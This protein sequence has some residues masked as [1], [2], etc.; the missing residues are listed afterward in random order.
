[1]G[2]GTNPLLPDTDGDS[3]LDGDEV[4]QYGTNPL[5]PDSDSDGLTDDE[6]ISLG[7]NPN[8]EDS[9]ND[10]MVDA[11]EISK[12]LNPLVNDSD[13]DNDGDGLTN[14]EEYYYWSS[15][16]LADTDN[17][18]L[19][20]LYE[21]LNGSNP[22]EA[23]TISDADND[24]LEAH[25]ETIFGTSDM[26]NDSDD[27]NL[28]DVWDKAT[29]IANEIRINERTDGNQSN[30]STVSN[31]DNYFVVWQGYGGREQSARY[32]I[33]GTVTD[34]YGNRVR[35][36][37]RISPNYT[38]T[39]SN[40]SVTTD[41]DNYFVV[42]DWTQ[43]D[44]SGAKVL[45]QLFDWRGDA[46]G[47][48][49]ELTGTG[50][51]NAS[52]AYMGDGTNRYLLVY[53][54]KDS[55]E[56]YGRFLDN[57]GNPLGTEFRIN[58]YTSS[59]QYNPAVACNGTNYLVAWQSNGQDGS[60]YGIYGQTINSAGEKVGSEIKISTYTSYE[61]STPSV[62]SDGINYYVTWHS[63]YQD[64]SEYGI[65][66]Q[67]LDGNGTRRGGE[68]KIN[69]T[70]YHHQ[71]SP[72]ATSN[73]TNYMVSWIHYYQL[74]GTWQ[75]DVRGKL[76]D[77]QGRVLGGEFTINKNITGNQYAPSVASD[78]N[79]YYC[80]W[81]SDSQDGS[82]WG[83]YG[84][85]VKWGYGTN[86]LLPDTD[87]DGMLDGDEILIGRDP[88][89][90]DIQLIY[91]EGGEYI[92]GGTTIGIEW[93]SSELTGAEVTIEFSNDGGINWIILAVIPRTATP[94]L[95]TVPTDKDSSIAKISITGSEGNIKDI[96]GEFTIDSVPP[97]L[98]T[99]NPLFTPTHYSYQNIS[100]TKEAGSSLWLN[101][102]EIISLNQNV[103]WSYKMILSEG[104]NP[105]VLFSRDAAGNQSANVSDVIVYNDAPP[106][107][108]NTLNLDGVD[109]G[110]VI[111]YNWTGY[112][113]Q[114]QGDI[115]YYRIYCEI[116]DAGFNNLSSLIPVATVPAGTFIYTLSGRIEDTGYFC[117]VV[118]V[119]TQGNAINAILP[120]QVTTLDNVPPENPSILQVVKFPTQLNLSWNHSPNTLGDLTKYNIYVNNSFRGYVPAAE[121]QYSVTG[122]NPGTAY[123]VLVKSVD[124]DNNE[125]SGISQSITTLLAHPATV[126]ITVIPSHTILTLQWVHA[127]QSHLLKHYAVYYDITPFTSVEG[128][129]PVTTTTGTSAVITGLENNTTYYIAVT[130]VNLSNEE[131]KSVSTVT[132]EPQP[133]SEGPTVTSFT[134]EGMNFTSGATV[135]KPGIFLLTA[136]DPAGVIKTEF[137]I[138]NVLVYTD[139]N[140]TGEYAFFY[141]A[142]LYEDGSYE[143]RTVVYD[144]F[145]HTTE[146][147]YTISLVLGIP[148]QPVITYP[149]DNHFTTDPTMTVSGTSDKY[150]QIVFYDNDSE[151]ATPVLVDSNGNFAQTVLFRNGLTQLEVA[152]RYTRPG[153][154]LS[155]QSAPVQ[156]RVDMPAPV[157]PV[158]VTALSQPDGY[159]RV[160]WAASASSYVTGYNIY[161][162]DASFTEIMQADKL[163][164][165]L[166][167]TLQFV[168]RPASDGI[169]YYRVTAANTAGK[170]S[171]VSMLAQCESDRIV[172]SAPII[173][174]PTE[175]TSS[176]SQVMVQGTKEAYASIWRVS[177]PSDVQV[178][179]ST[180]STT[181]TYLWN[182]QEGNNSVQF[183]QKDHALN[184][185]LTSAHLEIFY[186]PM[187]LDVP[188]TVT[189]N[190]TGTDFSISW[191][192]Y[193]EVLNNVDEYRI[194]LVTT[195]SD[196]SSLE[197]LTPIDVVPAGTKNYTFHGLIKYGTYYPAVVGV[198]PDGN[199]RLTTPAY[200]T[201]NLT[202]TTPPADVTNLTEIERTDDSIT[203]Q[204]VHS[205]DLGNDLAGYKVYKN[206]DGV[207]S[208]VS[209]LSTDFNFCAIDI[210]S[211][212]NEFSRLLWIR[213]T[214]FDQ[215]NNESAGD[216]DATL[217]IHTSLPNPYPISASQQ[218]MDVVLSW[219]HVSDLDQL[220]KYIVYGNDSRYN[221]VQPSFLQGETVNNSFTVSFPPPLPGSTEFY[222]DRYYAVTAVSKSGYENKYVTPTIVRIYRLFTPELAISSAD[223]SFSVVPAEAGEPFNIIARVRNIGTQDVNNVKVSFFEFDNEIGSVTHDIAFGST[224]T[225]TQTCT[226]SEGFKLITVKVDPDNDIDEIFEN[227][228]SANKVIQVGYPTYPSAKINVFA[229]DVTAYQD[230]VISVSGYAFYDF[231]EV[232]GNQDFP[233]QGAECRVTISDINTGAVLGVFSGANTWPNGFFSQ[234]I[235]TPETQGTY[236]ITCYV[237][238]RT[239][240]AEIVRFLTV[241]PEY[242]HD[243]KLF[244]DNIVCDP[245]NPDNDTDFTI[246][247]YV[248]NS[249]PATAT[250]VNIAFYDNDT[251]ITDVENEILLTGE[252]K[253]ISVTHRAPTGYHIIRV[254]VEADNETNIW[255]NKATKAV[256]VGNPQETVSFY[257]KPSADPVIACNSNLFSS[258]ISVYYDFDTTVQKEDYAALG[259]KSVMDLE[260]DSMLLVSKTNYTDA[261]GTAGFAMLAPDN[262][263]YYQLEYMCNDGTVASLFE[264]SLNVIICPPPVSRDVSVYSRNILF[265]DDSPDVNETIKV[266]S[267][268]DYQFSTTPPDPS[269]RIKYNDI[270]PV[271]HKLVSFNFFDETR[272]FPDPY[273]GTLTIF[274]NWHIT[275]GGAHIIQ[276]E[277]FPHFQQSTS[278]DK[279]TRLIYVGDE[280][281]I[282]HLEKTQLLWND[283]DGDSYF[284][285]NDTI[286]YVITYKNNTSSTYTGL[287]IF[288]VFDNDTYTAPAEISNGGYVDT[289]YQEG[290]TS[291]NPELAFDSDGDNEG[292]NVIVWQLG[293]IGPH[294]SGT[295]TYTL[296]VQAID[297]P[298]ITSSIAIAKTDQTDPVATSLDE[299]IVV[300]YAP[301]ARTAGSMFIRGAGVDVQLDGRTSY[302][303]NGDTIYY[304]WGVVSI[305]AG[306]TA[307]LDDDQSATPLFYADKVGTYAFILTVIDE[308]GQT[309]QPAFLSVYVYE[310]INL[311]LR[312]DSSLAV[313]ITFDAVIGAEYRILFSDS[314]AVL[315]SQSIQNWQILDEVTAL[316]SSVVYYD[317]GDANGFD[318]INGTPDDRIPP[319]QAGI[320]YY[321]VIPVDPLNAAG[322]LYAGSAIRSVQYQE[323]NEGRNYLSNC[324]EAN[325]L[326]ELVPPD[327]LPGAILY[328]H[329]T[330]AHF[331]I[332]GQ[333]TS[334]YVYSGSSPAEWRDPT[335]NISMN[336]ELI[337]VGVGIIVIIPENGGSQHISHTGN[338]ALTEDADIPIIGTD[339]NPVTWPYAQPVSL[340]ACG[341]IESGFTGGTTILNSDRI[342][343]FNSQ[344]QQYDLPVFLYQNGSV[345]Q[346]RY[347]NQTQCTRILRPGETILIKKSGLSN[348][349]TWHVKCPY[350]DQGEI[351]TE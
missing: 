134:F 307:E 155:T 171:P 328:P 79:N 51:A 3:I 348:L 269:T 233:V 19:S 201:V 265:D 28:T 97:V 170:E 185:S 126:S 96:S 252:T 182:L 245:V 183:Y 199:F 287:E 338:V 85:V 325:T 132:G 320:R 46:I 4:Y 130:S 109:I 15:P 196:Y 162:S 215:D 314:D 327:Q 148:S 250:D 90:T 45:G 294:E 39:Q 262:E 136:T 326:S 35:F 292:E 42:W 278:N 349:N 253:S 228:N 159:I 175:P 69:T 48:V 5:N 33:Y 324:M 14:S 179:A 30:P 18:G 52:C 36:D 220:E 258:Y 160:N 192:G 296:R 266:Y 211:A 332:N 149:P 209:T 235:R 288:D 50:R 102:I 346:W 336:S 178:V 169:W 302:D 194:Y 89:H 247:A 222:I 11:W 267:L 166:I 188:I 66:G 41:G 256:K 55:Y 261:K 219:A 56:V 2:Y 49:K 173:T 318:N 347:M 323:L 319:H 98:P 124:D 128:R 9:D 110:T 231:D 198:A 7:T 216:N 61:Q 193:N 127:A 264:S 195:Q 119:D 114:L 78:G 138:D 106:D 189:A 34:L 190:V 212:S 122:L 112:D 21:I 232:S 62:T 38:T 290:E 17:D 10:G 163:N 284:S 82:S 230:S 8:D 111:H 75:Y 71:H 93:A 280:S 207:E 135:T 341:L 27:D 6:E 210:D 180:A 91:P 249:G 254:E 337:P 177:S 301:V 282:I 65:Y 57:E 236:Y 117:A 165:T 298:R 77:K 146:T 140:A 16:L 151:F 99:L 277:L 94:Y 244:A 321:R 43:A 260:N 31:G 64:G 161:R 239:V 184:Q 286:Q 105:V 308:Y 84:S 125:S 80:A 275:A 309:S 150:T 242:R 291:F 334:A 115:D 300:N 176:V 63:R 129:T 26:D 116:N 24:W 47:S 81:Q 103:T 312:V 335:G 203:V 345:M 59:Y 217:N 263:G 304:Q 44:G 343:F 234:P 108:V 168:D 350:S 76:I 153:A 20:D 137:F 70:T 40:A 270:Y 187:P 58:T 229:N 204:W 22:V 104:D 322:T 273:S 246:T 25:E 293:N 191:N 315:H 29:Y 237:N 12:G 13:Y 281:R 73:G 95:W 333:H 208:L 206:V 276:A 67:L 213:V 310:P 259:V 218:G 238:D 131:Y 299:S 144:S 317:S 295:V 133:D 272:V 113:E 271:N 197:T 123:T 200:I 274:S 158:S 329:A 101:G 68:T 92:Q 1:W 32:G 142:S 313:E 202:D 227:N 174:A 311:S 157:A 23:I 340:S 241:I 214:A 145:L 331:W 205:S 344:T 37:F 172:P 248:T 88:L 339:Y 221:V 316:S 83:V 330:Q 167:T 303:S 164:S 141:N 121:N 181:W 100:G 86:P 225:F 255:N 283:Q 120:Q 54:D 305:P 289:T 147:L 268:I 342:Y 226:T 139:T 223:I 306:S 74:S 60:D 186:A 251:F 224:V 285:A 154:S 297:S 143:L 87:G 351:V 279:A 72:N 156:V 107:A 240:E 53:Q 243:L 257:I 152:A 118:A